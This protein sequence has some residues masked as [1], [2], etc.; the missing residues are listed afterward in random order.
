M[1]KIILNSGD[2]ALVD[3]SDYV[4]LS[5]YRWHLSNGYAVSRV[6]I[7]MKDGKQVK[8]TLRM[9]RIVNNTPMGCITDHIN[10]SKL[11]NRRSNLRTVNHS[12]N[13][14]NRLKPSNNT[15]GYKG[16]YW[17][18]SAKKWHARAWLKNRHYS[19]GLFSKAEDAFNAR[20]KFMT[21]VSGEY[22]HA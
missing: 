10:G 17:N 12:Q 9:H 5:A 15:S 21:G 3:D 16:V 22:Y 11:D 2:A 13:G 6:H 20:I 14:L 8:K 7:G 4:E 19:I 1:R 18:E